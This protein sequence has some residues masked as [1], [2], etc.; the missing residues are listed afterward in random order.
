[1]AC[2]VM[3]RLKMMWSSRPCST[4]AA[5]EALLAKLDEFAAEL[6]RF[7][8]ELVALIPGAEGNEQRVHG[9]M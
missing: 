5:G 3:C 9:S 7:R 4:G 8:A 1:V 6:L 2:C